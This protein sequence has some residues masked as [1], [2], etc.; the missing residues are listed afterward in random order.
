LIGYLTGPTVQPN[1]TYL[2]KNNECLT[3]GYKF[4][5]L[6]I[7]WNTPDKP[8]VINPDNLL[9]DQIEPYGHAVSEE[10][11]VIREEIDYSLAKDASGKLN[12]YKSKQVTEFNNGKPQQVEEY[13]NPLNNG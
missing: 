9:T 8:N 12:L 7:Y 2:V 13:P 11:P 1:E 5:S 3:K 4:N 10:N 6:R